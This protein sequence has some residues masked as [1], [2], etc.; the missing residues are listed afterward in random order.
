[1]RLDG[2][3]IPV[4]DDHP[5]TVTFNH[6]GAGYLNSFGAYKVDSETGEISDVQ[7]IWDNASLQGSG[8]DLIANQSG[9]TLETEP[10][11]QIG[12]FI[13]GD[14]ASAND[15]S[16]MQDGH[17][18]FRTPDGDGAAITDSAP[19]LWHIAAD[20][21]ATE[22]QNHIYH[23]AG[24]GEN[25]SLN[26]DNKLHTVGLL[27]TE[28]GTIKLGFEDL[29][30]GGD[31]DFDDAVFTVDVGQANAQV[32][33][34]HYEAN[35]TS[36]DDRAEISEHSVMN[37]ENVADKIEGGLG[38]DTIDGMQGNDLLA[39]DGAGDEWSL[40]DGEW[41]FDASKIVDGGA[42]QDVDD[43]HI[44]G[45]EGNDVLLGGR[46]ND[47]LEGGAGDDTLNAGEGNDRAFGGTGQD[48]I[49]LEDGNDYAEGGAGADVINAGSGN[50]VIFGDEGSLVDNGDTTNATSGGKGWDNWAARGSWSEDVS[51]ASDPDA[52][53]QAKSIFQNVTTSAGEE[54]SLSFDLGL[55]NPGLASAT[56]VEIYWN[57]ELID[58]VSP[59][60]ALF[61][62][63]SVSVTGTGGEDKL[64]F[65]EIVDKS[66][67]TSS[68]NGIFSEDVSLQING[69]SVDV[70]AFAAGQSNL[71]QV[72]SGQLNLYAPAE[73]TY[74]S[75]GEPFGFN[76]NA[77]GY[78]TADNLLYG[79]ASNGA[80]GTDAHGNAVGRHDLVVIDAEGNV[81]KLGHADFDQHIS[82]SVYVGDFGPDGD[83]WVMSGGDRDQ[84]FRVDL[85]ATSDTGEVSYQSV[86]IPRAQAQHGFADMSYVESENAFF[87]V[88]SKGEIYKIDPF[89]LVDGEAQVTSIP[90]TTLQTEDGEVS[91]VPTGSAWGAVFTD[92]DGNLYAG[93]NKGDHDLD[94]STG[95]SGAIYRIDNYTD[96]EATAVLLSE[97]PTTGS[98][99]GASDP[100]SASAFD[101]LDGDAGALLNNINLVAGSGED[102][103][104]RAG[105]GN[106][107]AHGGG[108]NDEIMGQEGDDL[109]TGD[110]GNDSVF[111]D[112]GDDAVFGGSG[113]DH[114]EGNAG[115]D[116][117]SGGM[118]NDTVMGGT[119]DD[120]LSGGAGSDNLV[121]GAGSDRIEGGS[122]DD[123]IWG[124]E[125][126]GENT[127]LGYLT[128]PIRQT[129][130]G[131][132][133]EH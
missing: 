89:N 93:L 66:A 86:P 123:H 15:F 103:Q 112:D 20:G 27:N 127:I 61:D 79:F 75:V 105:E 118:G 54:Y 32:L 69:E 114:V 53:V 6:E 120:I 70:P 36:A 12:F 82:G 31:K 30:N 25:A 21:T 124:G 68:D 76:V 44:M 26:P 119:G 91:G 81:H 107:E 2:S 74:E 122:G 50:D 87:A 14:S 128:D 42:P 83:L 64:E 121:G 94:A 104:I 72:I 80:N 23:T 117:V 110:A 19:T 132:L 88:T 78:N 96:G 100:R 33:N 22:L 63:H 71:Y 52:T 77:V 85:D 11:D 40:V 9:V 37:D 73:G 47:T 101:Q 116:S 129:F 57:G 98:N 131:A 8:G 60:S 41:V 29:Y 130:A 7:I 55:S 5:V 90:I 48:T 24:Y 111:G 92:V 108:G 16:A 45:D 67:V 102:D 133:S 62:S 4:Q 126:G 49:N 125:W 3:I 99:D 18:E 17:F 84:V 38:A 65:R 34:A 59:D 106:D 115:S 46:G 95:Q 28:E 109:L 10:G 13:I 97:A 35:P 51:Q 113:D 43:D 56:T 1:M 58:S 39:G